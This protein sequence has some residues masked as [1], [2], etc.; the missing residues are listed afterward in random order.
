M[1]PFLKR[2][3]AGSFCLLMAGCGGP[4][5]EDY[6]RVEPSKAEVAP[7]TLTIDLYRDS[8][9]LTVDAVDQLAAALLELSGGAVKL[10]TVF[11]AQP[12]AALQSGSAQLALLTNRDILEAAPELSFLD[13]PFFWDSP[14]QYLTVLGAEGGLVRG[15]GDLSAALGG[16]VLGV[17]YGGR[18]VLLSRGVFY[19][20][21]A[22]AGST[23]GVLEGSG[24]SGFFADIGEDLQAQELAEGDQEE[25]FG[26]LEDREA[27]FIECPIL[28]LD[29]GELPESLKSLEDTGHRFRG[30]WLVL[31]DGAVD[32]RTA[33]ILR[34]AAAY[35]PESARAKRVR[36]E[37]D[38]LEAL[39]AG[40]VKVTQTDHHALHRAAREYFRRS[41]EELGCSE[42][43][44]EELGVFLGY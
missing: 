24:G 39:A 25:L 44:W 27:K 19:E 33:D 9:W 32:A 20:E 11:S 1:R 29:P 3:L 31:R 23:V 36:A 15:S 28:A 30:L 17:W 14:E 21:I 12:A 2:L 7:Q 43:V 41:R 42:E 35:V 38:R 8:D 16:E 5:L 4:R 40:E 13:W 22:F 37:E 26:L 10:E 34:A 18:M 6:P